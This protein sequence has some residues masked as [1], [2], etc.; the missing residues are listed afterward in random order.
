MPNFGFTTRK[1]SMIILDKVDLTLRRYLISKYP[2]YQLCIHC[3]V[4][5]AVCTAAQLT[6]FNI[7][8]V[9]LNIDRGQTVT[10][11]N[12]LAKCMVCGKCEMVCPKNVSNRRIVLFINKYLQ[13]QHG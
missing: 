6:S 3:G 12:E 8:E 1:D 7:R 11:K 5:S 9:K 13:E 10:L 2:E 4:C